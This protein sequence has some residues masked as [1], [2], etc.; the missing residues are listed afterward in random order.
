MT[1]RVQPKPPI[2]RQ[3]HF[4]QMEDIH[5]LWH[6]S[7]TPRFSPALLACDLKTLAGDTRYYPVTD[8][9]DLCLL[10]DGDDAFQFGKAR[11]TDMARVEV[12]GRVKPL[13]LG[14]GEKLFDCIHLVFFPTGVVGAEFNH[15]AP[16]MSDL[17]EYLVSKLKSCTPVTFERLVHRD[18]MERLGHLREVKLI[19][20]RIDATRSDILTPFGDGWID[21]S[22]WMHQELGVGTVEFTLRA[23]NTA[24][25][26][27][28]D[29]ALSAV[30]EMLAGPDLTSAA[31]KFRIH[32]VPDGSDMTITIDLLDDKLMTSVEVPRH[33][34][35]NPDRYREFIYTK[36]RDA[37][38]TLRQEIMQ[39]A[40][41]VA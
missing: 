13:T 10:S 6:G 14:L 30:R 25:R 8:E 16:K 28:R 37:Y 23:G 19:E 12:N 35:R 11:K 17:T 3:I 32:A 26:P 18:V 22:Q 29:R 41:I 27:L 38:G 20:M 24:H 21:T 36:I 34:Y 15:V 33:V 2:V 5:D 4:Y 39:A 40:R 1:A 7:S 31:D 9:F